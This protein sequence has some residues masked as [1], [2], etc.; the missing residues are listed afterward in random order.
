MNIIAQN[1]LII[2]SIPITKN[3]IIDNQYEY[4]GFT[5]YV[6]DLILNTSVGLEVNIAYLLNGVLDTG[7]YLNDGNY[8][9]LKKYIILTGIDYSNWTNDD[10]YINSWVTN[11]FQYV[12]D[13]KL[14]IPCLK[15]NMN[16]I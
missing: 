2:V 4:F 7:N 5:C 1:P 12:I 13:S 9:Y 14:K 8:S 6:N 3:V 16:R 11:N 10:S 15:H